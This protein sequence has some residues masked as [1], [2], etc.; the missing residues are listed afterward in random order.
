[1]KIQE[2]PLPTHA[3]ERLAALRAETGLKLPTA[4]SS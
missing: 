4:A 1:M 3:A 2:L